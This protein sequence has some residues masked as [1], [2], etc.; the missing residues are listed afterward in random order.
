MLSAI[1]RTLILLGRSVSSFVCLLLRQMQV[2][3]IL[4][5]TA[6]LATFWLAGRMSWLVWIPLLAVLAL[7][8]YMIYLMI[9][10]R[11][12]WS[13]PAKP[14]VLAKAGVVLHLTPVLLII[15]ATYLLG[16]WRGISERSHAEPRLPS[17]HIQGDY[18][19]DISS[20]I[21]AWDASLQQ[22]LDNCSGY[23]GQEGTDYERR[24]LRSRRTSKKDKASA[25]AMLSN[26]DVFDA[27]WKQGMEAL[28]KSRAYAHRRQ[29]LQA[30]WALSS[31]LAAVTRCDSCSAPTNEVVRAMNANAKNYVWNQ[32]DFAGSRTVQAL[33]WRIA[34]NY[35]EYFQYFQIQQYSGHQALANR[36]PVQDL[37]SYIS[38]YTLREYCSLLG[39]IRGAQGILPDQRLFHEWIKDFPTTSIRRAQSI[40]TGVIKS[41]R[42]H[43]LDRRDLQDN[44]GILRSWTQ[45]PDDLVY[46]FTYGIGT[47]KQAVDIRSW[48]EQ[49]SSL[50]LA[51]KTDRSLS[52]ARAAIRG[53]RALG[54]DGVICEYALLGNALYESN[55]PQDM[56]HADSTVAYEVSRPRQ[57][58]GRS[59]RYRHRLIVKIMRKD[60]VPAS[61]W[62]E[63]EWRVEK[64]RKKG[65][66]LLHCDSG[67]PLVW[68]FY[69][70]TK[71]RMR[72]AGTGEWGPEVTLEG[73]GSEA[74]YNMRTALPFSRAEYCSSIASSE[75]AAQLAGEMA[76][77]LQNGTDPKRLV[78]VDQRHV[79]S[80]L[81]GDEYISH[82]EMTSVRNPGTRSAAYYFDGYRPRDKLSYRLSVTDGSGTHGIDVDSSVQWIDK[83]AGYFVH[84]VTVPAH[85]VVDISEK[86]DYDVARTQ[87][88]LWYPFN[89]PKVFFTRV[90]PGEHKSHRFDVQLKVPGYT[91]DSASGTYRVVEIPVTREGWPDVDNAVYKQVKPFRPETGGAYHLVDTFDCYNSKEIRMILRPTWPG[92]WSLGV[93]GLLTLALCCMYCG[94]YYGKMG[95]FR[96]GQMWY[97][98]CGLLRIPF[99]GEPGALCFYVH[100]VPNEGGK[101]I[102]VS[103]ALALLVTCAVWGSVCVAIKCPPGAFLFEF[104]PLL[105][106]LMFILALLLLALYSLPGLMMLR[107]MSFLRSLLGDRVYAMQGH[108]RPQGDRDAH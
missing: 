97:F 87:D 49:T 28:S 89:R 35:C 73:K 79:V 7:E 51:R 80:S 10:I 94:Q 21:A 62:V 29:Y 4:A 77:F 76:R 50:Q 83:D 63:G 36:S 99:P 27:S 95:P 85:S 58:A 9:C 39:D 67:Q 18:D 53:L 26:K 46:A 15:L 90:Y 75:V 103:P 84:R 96:P 38:W 3:S 106:V 107:L 54:A 30:L 71:V 92:P 24:L 17:I 43:P 11:R 59:D 78:E 42:A 65:V 40:A 88:T 37:G 93:L 72:I 44:L 13:L 45:R 33:E 105:I 56:R 12:S 66:R 32:P 69:Y 47:W 6:V 1:T 41:S 57:N 64:H 68:S 74:H 52:K 81:Q 8:A 108:T 101:C 86:A 19:K 102:T 48:A 98:V 55:I 14:D 100:R 22:R 23:Y 91:L 31:C 104:S 61:D 34:E 60:R 70:D 5:T 25:K 2:R 16:H 82:T 20:V